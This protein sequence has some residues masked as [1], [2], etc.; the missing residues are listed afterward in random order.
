MRYPSVTTVLG[1][2]ADFSGIPAAT[3]A[4]AADRGSRVH[5]YCAAI[6]Q[7]LWLPDEIDQD[8]QGFVASFQKWFGMVVEVLQVERRLADPSLGFDGQPDL[9]VRIQG[10]ELPALVDIKTP[11]TKN[12]LWAAQLSAYKHLAKRNGFE[13]GRIFSLR[14]RQDGGWPKADEYHDDQRHFAAFLSALNAF[15]WFRAA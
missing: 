6:A 15:R 5:A 1:P 3:L 7:G 12:R 4:Q 8:C 2:Y 13:V 10:D 14:L 11:A 9:I